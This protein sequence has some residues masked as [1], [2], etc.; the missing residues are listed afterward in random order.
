MDYL[1]TIIIST[2]VDVNPLLH[3]DELENE[4]TT[5]LVYF[6]FRLYHQEEQ[7]LSERQFTELEIDDIFFESTS[8]AFGVKIK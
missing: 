1:Y 4:L 7:L 8:I 5:E 2:K 3:I 6:T